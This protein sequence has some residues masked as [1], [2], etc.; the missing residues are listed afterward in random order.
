MLY[1]PRLDCF[2]LENVGVKAWRRRQ[3]HSVASSVLAQTPAQP[4]SAEPQCCSIGRKKT[5]G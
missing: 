2:R 5:I 1:Y 4:Q 3:L